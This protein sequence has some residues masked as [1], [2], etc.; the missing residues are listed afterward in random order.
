M[1]RPRRVTLS[2]GRVMRLALATGPRGADFLHHPAANAFSR[3]LAGRF[4]CHSTRHGQ[5]ESPR[6][7]SGLGEGRDLVAAAAP[8][9]CRSPP[10]RGDVDGRI[11]FFGPVSLAPGR[12][13]P[14][15]AR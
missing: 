8:V 5:P 12:C 7:W 11:T 10:W 1:S 14:S 4:F 15:L 3:R 6:G 9:S 2:R 13:R